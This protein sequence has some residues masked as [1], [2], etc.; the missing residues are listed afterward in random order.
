[1]AYTILIAEDDRDIVNLLKLYLES[2][3][4]RTVTAEN[5]TDAYKLILE[6]KIDLAVLDIMMPEMDG[7]ELAVKIRKK[8]DFPI[9]FLSAKNQDNDKILGLNL[10][11]DD[12]MTKPFNP[13]EIIARINSNLRRAYELGYE[14]KDVSS[15]LQNGGLVLDMDA[16][17]VKRDG[18]SIF[19][20]PSEFKILALLMKNP[21]KVFTKAQIYQSINGDF[22]ESDEN[23]IIVHISKIRDKLGDNS[24]NPQYIKNIRGLGYKIEKK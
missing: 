17:T 6:E 20:T 23:S 1:M 11:A 18:E 5:G 7:Y 14:V 13:L 9:I 24:K 2:N 15:Q 22:Y 12:Y 8:Y 10:G 16:M 19:L 21:G 3:G 4:Y